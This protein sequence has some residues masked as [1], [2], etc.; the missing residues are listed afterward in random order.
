[1]LKVRA[2]FRSFGSKTSSTS[3]PW[4]CL[5]CQSKSQWQY[6]KASSSA[7]PAE[8]AKPAKVSNPP[9]AVPPEKK[10]ARGEA[11]ILKP[12]NRLMGVDDPP[13][14][15]QNPAK[16]PRPLDERRDAY[17]KR[18]AHDERK[19]KMCGLSPSSNIYAACLTSFK[20]DAS[21][22][23]CHRYAELNRP[24]YGDWARMRH[25][26]G[27]T[28]LAPETAFRSDVAKYF[29][30]FQGYTLADSWSYLDTTTILKGKTTIV[31]YASQTWAAWQV[32]S[33]VGKKEN[34]ELAKALEQLKD[35]GL[36]KMVINYEDNFLKKIIVYLFLWYARRRNDR[37]DGRDMR[38]RSLVVTRGVDREFFEK[39]L[40]MTNLRVGHIYLIDR[41]CKIRWV[42]NGY[43]SE[44]EKAS[45]VRVARGLVQELKG[46]EGTKKKAAKRSPVAKKVNE[47]KPLAAMII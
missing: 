22:L 14:A 17:W 35:H 2:E 28:F 4:I 29:P 9:Q 13:K 12:L 42:G 18:E 23:L 41:H 5:A 34:P 26:K 16:D 36:Q 25:H 33:F 39:G 3:I 38:A 43:A 46:H 19:R 11:P 40:G 27:K 8:P 30:N 21:L 31:C 47:P 7:T 44:E 37:E 24:Y 1:M 10:P 20:T 15:G 32:Q 45:L 6:R